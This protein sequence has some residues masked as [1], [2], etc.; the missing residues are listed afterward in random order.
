[1]DSVISGLRRLDT[2]KETALLIL[3]YIAKYVRKLTRPRNSYSE[4]KELLWVAF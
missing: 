3:G 4:G 2:H 1:M